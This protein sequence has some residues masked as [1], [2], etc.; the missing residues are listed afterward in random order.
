MTKRNFII[1]TLC[2]FIIALSA[3]VFVACDS[4]SEPE[5]D[6]EKY[7]CLFPADEITEPGY[8][9]I[10]DS[11]LPPE[12]FVGT[13][14][15]E[16]T[17]YMEVAPNKDEWEYEISDRI[18][19]EYLHDHLDYLYGIGRKVVITYIP[20]IAG[21]S[22]ISTDDIRHDGFEEFELSV[23]YRNDSI[24]ARFAEIQYAGLLTMVANSREFDENA[25]DFN[26]YYYGLHDVYVNVDG[27][28]L[29][30]KEALGY[31]KVTLDGVIAECNRKASLGLIEDYEYK[32]GGSVLYDFADYKIIKYHTL[33]GN[34]DVFIGTSD[35]DINAKN[36]TEVC[37]GVYPWRDLGVRLKAE[38][39]TRSGGNLIFTTHEADVT[40]TLQTGEAFYLEK[41]SGR[42]WISCDT[43]PTIDYAFNMV[44]YLIDSEKGFEL[45]TEWEWLYG[46][47]AAGKYRIAKEVMDFRET[48]DFDEQVYYAY[49]EIPQEDICAYPANSN[50]ENKPI[51]EEVAIQIAEEVAFNTYGDTINDEKPFKA[52]YVEDEEYWL[53][54]G[55]MKELM[56]GGVAEIKISSN[57]E[58]LEVTHGK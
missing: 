8:D 50:D 53:V 30:L 28:T 34:R 57:G 26:L 10:P 16:D 21:G 27:E 17:Y 24:P 48:G 6:E 19:V 12:S 38:N 47:L 43:R 39:V 22:T 49:F 1:L 46:K 40:G 41:L 44:A 51:T 15:E 11:E 35:M 5:S 18:R 54:T 37:V 7:A 4:K 2:T 56:H 33:D 29:P 13:V 55:T 14:L 52:I 36:A 9:E 25:S 3:T 45:K 31:G 32:D 58:V 20:P 42:K 23:Q